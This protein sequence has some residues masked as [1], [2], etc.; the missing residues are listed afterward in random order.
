MD[1]VKLNLNALSVRDKDGK[2][3]SFNS[4]Y[5]GDA[6]GTS[7][8][9]VTDNTLSIPGAAADAKA[10][11]DA[12]A[13]TNAAITYL[14]ENPVKLKDTDIQMTDVFSGN[15]LNSILSYAVLLLDG[16]AD[17]S[18]IPSSDH[19]NALIDAKLT[20][21]ESLADDILEVM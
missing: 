5:G 3:H 21:L 9:I 14:T 13:E 19:I 4:L 10:V 17:T 12:I 18:D 11:G 20:P 15:N 2:L 8:D 7:V 6:S 1:S 16:K